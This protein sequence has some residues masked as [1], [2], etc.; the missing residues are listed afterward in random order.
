ML[1]TCGACQAGRRIVLDAAGEGSNGSEF[2]RPLY[3]LSS[4]E[5]NEGISTVVPT[6]A[7]DA[8]HHSSRARETARLARGPQSLPLTFQGRGF[9]RDSLSYRE[10]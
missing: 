8:N 7:Y 5:A 10:R 4:P 3:F 9:R 1:L 2:L 6:T